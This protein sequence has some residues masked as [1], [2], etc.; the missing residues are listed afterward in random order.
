MNLPKSIFKIIIVFLFLTHNSFATTPIPGVGVVIKKNP[1]GGSITVPTENGGGFSIKLE[2]GVYELSF[3]QDQLQTSINGIIK[4]DY[5]KSNYQY[6]GSGVEMVLDN[7]AI[8]VNIKPSQ[9]DRFTIDKQNSFTITVPKGGAT[10]SGKLSW[11]DAVMTNS[12][13]CPEGFTM[14][15]GECVPINPGNQQLRTEGKTKGKV[16]DPGPKSPMITVGNSNNSPSLNASLNANGGTSASTGVSNSFSF[17]PSLGLELQ[18]NHFGIGIDAGTFNTNPNFDFDA[19]AAPLQNLDF[20]TITNTKNNYTSTYLMIGPQYT[21]SLGGCSTPLHNKLTFTVA[22]KGGLTFNKTPEFSITDNSTPPK[23]VA[24]YE[25][26]QDYKKNA[27]SLKPSISFAYWISKSIALTANAQYLMQTGQEE[28]TTAYRDL[29]AVNFNLNPQEVKSQILAAPKVV[30]TTKGPDKYVSF[31]FGITYNFNKGGGDCDDKSDITSSGVQKKGI[32]ENGLKK[33]D[34]ETNS[35]ETQRKGITE[36]GLKKNDV[37]TTT[38]D[39]D[40]TNATGENTTNKKGWDGSIK[41]NKAVETASD[42]AQGKGINEN[43][44]K[45]IEQRESLEKNDSEKKGGDRTIKEYVSETRYGEIKP[46]LAKDGSIVYF[47]YEEDFLVEDQNMCDVLGVKEFAIKKGKYKVNYDNSTMGGKLIWTLRKPI[48][49]KNI[50]NIETKI[51]QTTGGKHKHCSE[52]SNCCVATI[53]SFSTNDNL[54][55][56]YFKP[57][58]INGNCSTIELQFIE[59]KTPRPS[60]E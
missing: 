58:V 47:E 48:N 8:S 39:G 33:N 38:V 50:S 27:F 31:G 54:Q 20:L 9:G 19:Y 18:W 22:L 56:F 46:W 5:P 28:F 1:G 2:E 23:N 44:L 11:N 3:P 30:S 16:K 26:P 29:S 15:N 57:I 36:N 24:S 60:S 4:T 10:L 25:A 55:S 59:V 34:V 45:K 41:G 13:I 12:K 21:V 35:D 49:L 17:N 7:S 52:P 43:G 51:F 14:Q 42:A 6:D 32:Q 40:N 37:E 53:F